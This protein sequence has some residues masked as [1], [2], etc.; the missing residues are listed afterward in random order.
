MMKSK[1]VSTGGSRTPFIVVDGSLLDGRS[2]SRTPTNSED[3]AICNNSLRLFGGSRI[4][5]LFKCFK[6]AV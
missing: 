5:W 1:V 2:R 6:F 4:F 3:G